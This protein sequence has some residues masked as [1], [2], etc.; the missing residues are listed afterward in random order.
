MH[1]DHQDELILARP[2]APGDATLLPMARPVPP[3]F[4]AEL[5]ADRCDPMGLYRVPRNNAWIDIGLIFV[6]VLSFEIFVYLIVETA[7]GAGVPMPEGETGAAPDDTYG[8]L[9]LPLMFVRALGASL[10]VLVVVRWRS[11]SAASVGLTTRD[12]T[13]NSLLGIVGTVFAYVLI[14][15]AAVVMWL[16]NP[17]AIKGL[18]EN[19]D[20]LR[21]L[22]PPM[23]PVLFL[24]L[25]LVIGFYEELLFRGF[26]MTRLRRATGSWAPAVIASTIVFTALHAAEQTPQALVMITILSL[27]FSGLTIWRRSIVPAIIAH[28]LFNLSQFLLLHFTVPGVEM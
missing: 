3:E 12:F 24:P 23:H 2:M 27:V 17:A 25:T 16:I 5:R 14:A 7:L 21:E 26:L 1:D 9:F 10:A 22:V 20:Q 4:F 28:M 11:Q 8:R 15:V 13:I 19:A 6:L 18:E